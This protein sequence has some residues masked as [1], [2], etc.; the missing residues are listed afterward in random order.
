V[1]QTQGK[2]KG[3]PGNGRKGKT[4]ISR[5]GKGSMFPGKRREIFPGKE[6]GKARERVREREWQG[7]GI[8]PGKGKHISGQEKGNGKGYFQEG[9]PYFYCFSTYFKQ[10]RGKGKLGKRGKGNASEAKGETASQDLL[11]QTYEIKQIRLT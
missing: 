9:Q 6:I 4:N 5:Q 7:K 11:T 8:F 3:K 1:F 2:G 10:G